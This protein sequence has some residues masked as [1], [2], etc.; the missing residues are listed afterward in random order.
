MTAEEILIIFTALVAVYFLFFKREKFGMTEDEAYKKARIAR[1]EANN[2]YEQALINK[3]RADI[4]AELEKN[5]IDAK[6][7]EQK[8]I[9]DNKV[10]EAEIKAKEAENKAKEAENKAKEEEKP[11][12][13]VVAMKPYDP[14]PFGNPIEKRGYFEDRALF[15]KPIN[16]TNEEIDLFESMGIPIEIASE[17]RN[18]GLSTE[19]IIMSK[20]WAKF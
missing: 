17:L 18:K 5:K 14:S 3:T 7:A 20:K 12:G 8:T 4:E 16:F 9:E 1:E 2:V 15:A 11:F 10:I 6:L 19:D 13:P